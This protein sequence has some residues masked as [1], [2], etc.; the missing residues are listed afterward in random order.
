MKYLHAEGKMA[1]EKLR[2]GRKGSRRTHRETGQDGRKS[3][4]KDGILGGMGRSKASDGQS[5]SR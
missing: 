5:G 3:S 4:G 1:I 2:S